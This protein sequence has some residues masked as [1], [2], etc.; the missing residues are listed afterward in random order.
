MCAAA[1][2]WLTDAAEWDHLGDW[3]RNRRVEQSLLL[4][5]FLWL[6]T[7]GLAAILYFALRWIGL[8]DGATIISVIFA[9]LPIVLILVPFALQVA[10]S[11]WRTRR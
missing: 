2:S 8:G 3:E 1:A 4:G 11:I 7:S 5:V 9:F 6:V 10:A